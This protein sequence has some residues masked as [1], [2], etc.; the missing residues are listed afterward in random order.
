MISL[1]NH[2][3][4]EVAVRSLQLTQMYVCISIY[5]YIVDSWCLVRMLMVFMHFEHTHILIWHR[6]HMLSVLGTGYR[7]LNHLMDC[8][9]C[10]LHRCHRLLDQNPRAPCEPVCLFWW[11]FLVLAHFCVVDFFWVSQPKNRMAAKV[12][13]K[14]HN[15]ATLAQD[16]PFF[17]KKK[18]KLRWSSA[19]LLVLR[20]SPSAS[21]A[22]ASVTTRRPH[23]AGGRSYSL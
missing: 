23:G 11:A 3:S 17:D 2:D 22:A 14:S 5:I 15:L 19:D 16:P 21:T 6:V 10:I 8:K 9:G 20:P 7:P 13:Y 12:S 1:I 18:A 4:S